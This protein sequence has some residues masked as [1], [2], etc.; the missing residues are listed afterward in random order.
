MPLTPT[1]I[2]KDLKNNELD[3]SSAIE[4][5]I[6]LIENAEN[7]KTRTESIEILEKINVK[8]KKVFKVLEN[9]FISDSNEKVRCLSSQVLKTLFLND[10]IPV[11]KWGLQHERSLNCLI[12]IIANLGDINNNKAKAI[13]MKKFQEINKKKYKYNIKPIVEE[14]SV[15]VLS[16]HE[17]AEILINYYVISSLKLKF[18]YVK[19]ENSRNGTIISLDLSNVEYQGLG[20]NKLTNSLESIL[21]LSFLKKL[22]LSNNQIKNLPEFIKQSKNLEFLDLSFNNLSRLP[23]SISSIFNLKILNLKSNNIRYVPESIG[24]LPNLEQLI[25]RDNYLDKLPD[26]ICSLSKLKILDL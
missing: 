20:L 13:L 10:A 15:E 4:L 6:S 7:I 26:S 23:K 22:D 21:S 11:L 14:K 3:R 2:Y 17:L 5:L 9:L 1:A 19:F 12:S 24:S 18:G 25:L 16:N 8:D